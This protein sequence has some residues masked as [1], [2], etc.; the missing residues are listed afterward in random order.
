[1]LSLRLFVEGLQVLAVEL[2][3]NRV[4]VDGAGVEDVVHSAE[5]R[6]NTKR[7]D[8][9]W[10]SHDVVRHPEIWTTTNAI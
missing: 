7:S 5:S 1:M 8:R 9:V 10:V 2:D 3:A 4:V 6:N